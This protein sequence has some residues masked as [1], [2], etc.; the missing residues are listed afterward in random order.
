MIKNDVAQ[1]RGGG[2]A[3]QARQAYAVPD[4]RLRVLQRALCSCDEREREGEREGGRERES[5]C[6]ETVSQYRE[7][8]SIPTRS[9][10]VWIGLDRTKLDSNEFESI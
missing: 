5:S 6:V 9:K 1:Y 4:G 7:F 2:S 8:E 3:G 10:R